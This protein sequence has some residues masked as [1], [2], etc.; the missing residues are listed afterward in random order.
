[1]TASHDKPVLTGTVAVPVT[2]YVPIGEMYKSTNADEMKLFAMGALALKLAE[3]RIHLGDL[4][5]PFSFMGVA[6]TDAFV[7][8]DGEQTAEPDGETTGVKQ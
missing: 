4:G 6:M 2:F 7:E 3:T 5:Y 8:V 1:M